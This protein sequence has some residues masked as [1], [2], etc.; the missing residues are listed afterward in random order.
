MSVDGGVDI[1]EVIKGD[2]LN[3][4]DMSNFQIETPKKN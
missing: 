3:I 1:S 4:N 2:H